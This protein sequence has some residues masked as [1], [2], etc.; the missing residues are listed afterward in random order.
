MAKVYFYYSAMNAGKSTTLLQ[1]SYNYKERGMDTLLFAPQ[2]D[3]RFGQVMVYSRI[4]LKQ[5]A[6]AFNE[7]FAFFN[8]VKRKKETHTE[9]KCILVD[10]AHFLKK[11]Q[12]AEL[13]L[14]ATKLNIAVLCYG[15]RSDFRGEPFEG[16]KYLLAWAEE[17]H[18]IKTICT[19]SRKATMNMRIDASGN[20][21]TQGA[22]IQVGG[23]ESYIS[24]CMKCFNLN[25]HLIDQ[26]QSEEEYEKLGH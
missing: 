14:I 1:A 15:L 26:F 18:E 7:E 4:G 24:T 17:L 10:E 2:I 22:Q 9:L 20:P 16:S 6:I 23:N 13:A 3:Q 5:E 8:F 19:C 12:I 11:R 21:L 25:T